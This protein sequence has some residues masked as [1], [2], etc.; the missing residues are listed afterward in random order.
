MKTVLSNLNTNYES[1][2]F[3]TKIKWYSILCISSVLISGLCFYFT[4]NFYSI[5]AGAALFI[6]FMISLLYAN[7]CRSK[8]S[9]ADGRLA[10]QTQL[11]LIDHLFWNGKGSLLNIRCRTGALSILCAKRYEEALITGVDSWGKRWEYGKNACETNA[12]A[13]KVNQQTTFC[14][15]DIAHLSF[16]DESFHAVIANFAFFKE[17]SVDDK[18]ILVK[19]ALRTL[20]KGG[21]FAFQDKFSSSRYFGDMNAFVEDLKASGITEVHYMHHVEKVCG[22]IPTFISTPWMFG[23]TGMLY[24][25]K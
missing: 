1:N 4:K 16:P 8:M 18:K 11:F 5:Y 6:V 15:E 13:E 14:H 7:A 3:S 9:F 10:E 12:T 17:R 21:S 19:E 23:G 22:F 25:V 2:E 24:G 20:K